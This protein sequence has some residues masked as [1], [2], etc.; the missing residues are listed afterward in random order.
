MIFF[1]KKKAKHTQKNKIMDKASANVSNLRGNGNINCNDNSLRNDC[2]ND[3]MLSYFCV[4][5]VL[6]MRDAFPCVQN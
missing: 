5:V 4:F 1:S 6:E 2:L 3:G